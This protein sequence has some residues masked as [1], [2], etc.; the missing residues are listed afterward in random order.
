MRVQVR[1][2]LVALGV[3][4]LSSSWA[5]QMYRWV[6]KEGHVHYTQQP[7]ARDAA[8]S[9][10]QKKLGGGNVV[11]GQTPFAL[12]QAM[13]KYP[14]VLYTSPGC[15]EGCSEARALLSKRGIPYREVSVS[16]QQTNDQLRKST[17][18]NKVPAL[19]VGTLV[20]KGFQPEA[21]HSA[22]DTAGYPR[23]PVFPGKPVKS[24][25]AKVE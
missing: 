19:M 18:D 17:G 1:K 22:L 23:S 10:E 9:V 13:Q 21:L 3:A 14:V 20:Q 2:A 16:D 7:P 8:K 6:D 24:S 25:G 4:A 5:Q 11:E 15:K 12:Q